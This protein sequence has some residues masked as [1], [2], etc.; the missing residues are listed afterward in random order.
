MFSVKQKKYIKKIDAKT[1]EDLITNIRNTN[2]SQSEIIDKLKIDD[3]FAKT[4]KQSSIDQVNIL[5]ENLINKT[6]F[7][8]L[9]TLQK[10]Y[11][12]IKIFNL[13]D[14]NMT[15]DYIKFLYIIPKEEILYSDVDT[16]INQGALYA[17]IYAYNN[18]ILNI[19]QDMI[20]YAKEEYNNDKTEVK[21]TIYNLF[22]QMYKDEQLIK[23]SEYNRKKFCKND[24]I[25]PAIIY[26]STAVVLPYLQVLPKDFILD[27]LFEE[28][29]PV[30]QNAFIQFDQSS[31][32]GG[33]S[34]IYSKTHFEDFI[35]D[36]KWIMDSN[37]YIINLPREDKFTVYGY[38]HN[39]DVIVNMILRNREKEIKDYILDPD[40]VMDKKYQP[41]FF[42]LRKT[43][44][45]KD[46]GIQP[47]ILKQMLSNDLFESYNSICKNQKNKESIP[48]EAYLVAANMFLED[49]KRI[50]DNS[51]PITQPTIVYRGSKTLYYSTTDKRTFKNNSFMST[52][53]GIWGPTNFTNRKLKCCIK[54]ITLKTGTKALF[55]DCITQYESETEILLP[56]DN[57]FKIISHEFNTYYDMP[58]IDQIDETSI[59][60]NFCIGRKNY[61]TVTTME[62]I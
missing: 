11:P 46:Y 57:E 47:N 36:R 9:R 14:D 10:E 27:L 3:E 40:R 39:G 5:A 20:D 52:S 44:L 51:P 1:I 22:N 32:L 26:K 58:S 49:L 60:D 31:Y 62:Q 21:L 41:L 56:P 6:Y 59:I 37:N 19:E 28:T 43:L 45:A 18:N 15:Q 24:E 8:A 55:M 30:R 29:Y 23:N 7:K 42:Q 16:M 33:L 25:I 34:S 12:N 4:L 2:I 35:L 61:M 17:L 13:M 38:T 53:Y 54:K 48:E 50:I